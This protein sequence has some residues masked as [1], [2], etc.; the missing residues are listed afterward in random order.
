[1]CTVSA[2]D[3]FTNDVGPFIWREFLPAALK[4]KTIVPAP[5]SQ[6]VGEELRSV[7]LGLDTQRKGVSAKKVVVSYIS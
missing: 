7:Q 3:I 2:T 1:M 6:I 5:E 4:S